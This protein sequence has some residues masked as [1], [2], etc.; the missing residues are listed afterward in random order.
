MIFITGDTHNRIDI[1]KLN[2]KNFPIQR[3]LTKDDYVIVCGDFGFVWDGGKNDQYWLDWLESR[4]FTTLWI[5]GNHEN[6]DLLE[7]YPVEEW[8]GGRVRK[9]R[10]SVI[11]L[12]RGEVFN[13]DGLKFFTFGGARSTDQEYRIPGRSWWPQEM[14]TKEEMN[15]GMENLESHGNRV[16]Y[17]LTHTAPLRFVTSMIIGDINDEKDEK[18]FCNYLDDIYERVE[19]KKWFC[20]HYHLD[21]S[22]DV[23]FRAVFEDIL[24]VF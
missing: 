6:F 23:D 10:E 7:E 9:I 20:G 2:T 18:V 24:E 12:S 4:S 22:L 5:D 14:P 3:E 17:I 13:I 8:N 15:R 1:S 19:F 21:R 11:H 16:D